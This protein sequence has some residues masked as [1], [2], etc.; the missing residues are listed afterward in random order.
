[1]PQGNYVWSTGDSVQQLEAGEGIYAV[2]VTA[3]NG[4]RS[5]T[6]QTVLR[7]APEVLVLGDTLI[8]EGGAAQVYVPLSGIEQA[9]W[10]NGS[11]S[12]TT[13]V[14]NGIHSVTVTDIYGC[15]ADDEFELSTVPS[16]I[17]NFNVTPPS[18]ANIGDEVKISDASI[19]NG[20]T[21]VGR[22]FSINDTLFWTGM[23]TTIVF[24]EKQSMTIQEVIYAS[25]GCTDTT[26]LNYVIEKIIVATNIMTPNGDGIN[27]YLGFKNLDVY[28]FNE[29]EIYN[30]W[31]TL[32]YASKQY[33]NNWDAYGMSDGTYFYVLKSA[34]GPVVKGYVTVLR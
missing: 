34:E 28:A 32:V 7:T 15:S 14:T 22:L 8:C 26:R 24:E 5:F 9:V 11:T 4:C 1:M 30:R 25:N 13:M 6:K 17:A 27:D 18:G 31:G 20:L 21:L 10:S 33:Q 3:A 29:I 12:D 19:A 16:P 2:T 23:D